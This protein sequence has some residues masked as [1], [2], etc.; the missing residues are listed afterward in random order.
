M[1][2]NRTACATL[3]LLLLYVTIIPKSFGLEDSDIIVS[4][5]DENRECT[6]QQF[7]CEGSNSCIPKPWVCDGDRDCEDGSDEKNCPITQNCLENL[8]T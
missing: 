7:R 6:Q 1:N 3:V 5:V 4:T 2:S 8:Y